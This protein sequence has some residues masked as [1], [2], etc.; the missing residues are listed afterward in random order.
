MHDRQALSPL[1]PFLS[2]CS[3]TTGYPLC[4]ANHHHAPP[5]S[6]TPAIQARVYAFNSVMIKEGHP[7]SFAFILLDPN[8]K[9][10]DGSKPDTSSSSSASPLS[11]TD[12]YILSRI[13]TGYL[14][15]PVDQINIPCSSHQRCFAFL[16]ITYLPD[17]LASYSP[18]LVYS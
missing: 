17:P 15:P 7:T 6:S 10:R 14:I 2:P 18:L 5:P 11:S 3:L 4:R 13:V 16:V 9:K 8:K 1:I 12:R